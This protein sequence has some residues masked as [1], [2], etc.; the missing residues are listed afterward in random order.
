MDLKEVL[1]YNNDPK[2]ILG[3]V[4]RVLAL[5]RGKLWLS[6]IIMELS[7]F[8]RTLSDTV[9]SDR[10]VVEAVRK[11]CSLGLVKMHKRLRAD[12]FKSKGIEDYLVELAIPL[13]EVWSIGDSRLNR[14]INVRNS[15]LGRRE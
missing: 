11:L 3:D 8:R 5:Y 10:D 14:Y 1:S 7:S 15:V 6:E 13:Y 9:P 2:M 4:I 12:L